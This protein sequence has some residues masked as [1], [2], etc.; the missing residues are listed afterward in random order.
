MT[1]TVD[2]RSAGPDADPEADTEQLRASARGWH[3][4]QLAVLGFIGLCGALHDAGAATGP[5]WVQELA[6]AG[7]RR[8]GG[9]VR[10]DRA[11]RA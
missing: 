1:D 7:D 4:V 5:R 2:L 9:G 3:G 6:R 10:R 8:L 11:G